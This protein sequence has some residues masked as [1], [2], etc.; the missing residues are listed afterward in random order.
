LQVKNRLPLGLIL[1]EDNL[2]GLGFIAGLQARALSR[3]CIGAVKCTA[4][5]AATNYAVT[6]FIF[7]QPREY[8]MLAL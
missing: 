2:A 7:T 5:A 8:S 4:A 1:C 6:R 3:R